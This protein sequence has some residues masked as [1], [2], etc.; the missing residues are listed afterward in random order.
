MFRGIVHVDSI[1]QVFLDP[2][3]ADALCDLMEDVQLDAKQR[4]FIWPDGQRLDLDQSV[5]ST[6]MWFATIVAGIPLRADRLGLTS[7]VRALNLRPKLYHRLL[8]HLHSAGVKLDPLAA[9]W[10][11]VVLGLFPSP[12]RVN[13]RLVLVG[14]A[15]RLP[16]A[17][18]RCRLSSC[19]ISTVEDDPPPRLG[20][21]YAA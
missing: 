21:L 20:P 14:A 10:A 19:C 5:L 16:S 2:V 7:I 6:F 3:S 8:A 18:R 12:V 9:L 4:K 13:G 15:L 17:A 11:Q 1:D